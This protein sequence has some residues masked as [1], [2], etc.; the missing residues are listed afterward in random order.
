VKSGEG[1]RTTGV[2][3]DLRT[4]RKARGLTLVT[5]ASRVGRSVGW[6]SQVE[7]N[8]SEPGLADLGRLAQALECPIALFFGDPDTPPEERGHVVRAGRRRSLG[9]IATGLVEELLSP[10]LGGSFEMFQS[11]MAPGASSPGTL[12]RR[13]EEAGYIVSGYLEMTIGERLFRL[14]P[15]DSF[16]LINEPMA[17]RNPR[18]EPCVAIWVIAPPV[19]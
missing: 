18:D 4:L 12:F 10:D 5:L 8:Q 1:A 14:G 3:G 9:T 19:Y 2:G 15:G 7:R 11:V 17:W 13:V 16:R 6:L